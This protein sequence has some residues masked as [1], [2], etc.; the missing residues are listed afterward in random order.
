VSDSAPE[1]TEESEEESE[2]HVSDMESYG[3]EDEGEHDE[4]EYMSLAEAV[5]EGM[6]PGRKPGDMKTALCKGTVI[7]RKFGGANSNE[8]GYPNAGWVVGKMITC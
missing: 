1:D 8:P 6:L 3:L 2:G 4:G 7:A 5:P